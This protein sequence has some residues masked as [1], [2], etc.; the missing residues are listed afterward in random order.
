MAD[1]DLRDQ[2]VE[3]Q[4]IAG[5]DLT[6]VAT[7]PPTALYQFKPDIA[8]FTGRDGQVARVVAHL[9]VAGQGGRTAP[10]LCAIA[11]M[12]GVGKSALAIHAAHLVADQFPDGQLYVNLRGADNAPLDAAE[13][14]AGFLS[15]LGINDQAIPKDQAGR[16]RFYRARL[17]NK[18]ALVVL[19][20]ARDE[21]QVR[22]LLPGS[23]SCAVLITSRRRLAALEGTLDLDLPVLTEPEALTLLRGLI[24]V[25]RS[26]ETEAASMA[27]TA[28]V[29]LCDRLPLALRIAGGTLRVKHHWS[30]A[31]YAARLSNERGRL[32]QLRLGDLE[33]RASFAVSYDELDATS[34]RLF[35]LLGVLTSP[36][37]AI[38]AAAALLESDLSVAQNA[39]E[40]LVDAQLLE[41]LIG[42]ANYY[43]I[44]D[45]LHLFARERL[46][47]ADPPDVQQATRLRA[48]YWY[49]GAS[50]SMN[51]LLTPDGCR[52]EA[53]ARVQG[54]T[55]AVNEEG[56]EILRSA[57]EWFE[58]ERTNLLAAIEVSYQA[59]VWDLV[60]TL[61]RN[62][63][64]FFDLR[65]LWMDWEKTEQFALD[66]AH[67]IGDRQGEGQA[68]NSLGSV[69]RQRGRWDEAI[70]LFED[71]L[72][73]RRALGDR[74]GEGT[75]LGNLGNAHYQRGHR[76]EATRSY[77]A[78][79]DIMRALGDRHREA[80]ILGGL[81]SVYR[82]QGRW[83]E[84]V[85][86]FT[87]SLAICQE[88][89][90][91]H[92]ESLA[93]G[94]LG[95]AYFER[96]RWDEATRYY[97]S[98]LRIARALGDRHGEDQTLGNLG[99][100]YSQRG[101]WDEAIRLFEDSLSIRRALGDRHGESQTLG[102]LG[103]VYDLRGHWDEAIRYY[104]QDL[105]ICRELGDRHGEGVTLGNLGSL[106][107][108]Q[109]R[110]DEA[111]DV[112]QDALVKMHPD[113]PEYRQLTLSIQQLNTDIMAQREAIPNARHRYRNRWRWLFSWG[114][115]KR[116]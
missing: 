2:H 21:A 41:P 112:W 66:A 64:T 71:S 90:D 13:V 38:G 47:A 87:Q 88:L 48:A 54:T 114:S 116:R 30:V 35:R 27:T 55:H 80:L 12:P 49:C 51:I 89:G 74:H 79:L 93:L 62:L 56:Q 19:D 40:G 102:N 113:S 42:V 36:D 8:D 94:K 110:W 31:D 91:R 37:V 60:V 78:S 98:S 81:G 83:D 82:Q 10:A 103:A 108:Q 16:E 3:T 20:N 97:E 111:S 28:I 57:L 68:L 86:L 61:A 52:R 59:E 45:L 73:I 75:T 32:E 115:N 34:A 4:Y 104:E 77:E 69:Y 9:G 1:F 44:H 84:A 11:G 22:P 46:D 106:Y 33:V 70:R 18:R 72:S 24:G 53:Q 26:Q 92:G 6:V 109:G 7:P 96:G 85:H 101:R 17:A 29:V 43:R 99:A 65:S 107:R 15:A 63:A 105:A 100:I 58:R 50:A 39:L 23:G 95:N 14:L 67:H 5:Q 25:E 76:D